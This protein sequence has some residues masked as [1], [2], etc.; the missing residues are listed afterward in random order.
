MPS[1]DRNDI[2]AGGRDPGGEDLLAKLVC[3]YMDRLIAGETI[4]GDRVLREHPDLG[5]SI[6]RE[7]RTFT[8][9]GGDGEDSGEEPRT[10]GTLGDFTLR[11]RLGS[12]GMGVVYAAWQNSL[13]REVALKVLPPGVAADARSS[14]RFLREAQIAARLSHPHIVPVYTTG[15]EGET[16]YYAMEYVEGETLAQAIARMRP[17]GGSSRET[18]EGD[19]TSAPLF[20][21]PRE[22][23]EFFLRFARAFAGVADG[24]QHAHER[25]VIHRDIKPSNLIF[26][27]EGRLRIL[28]FGLA[29]LEGHQS[30][31][32]SGGIAGTPLYMSPEQARACKIPI[33]HRTDIYSLGATMYE[34]L[35]GRPPFKGKDPNDTLSQIIERE[36]LDPTALDP[37]IPRDLETIVLKCL[38]KEAGDRFGT[39]EALAQDLRRFVRGDPIEARPPGR[40]ERA[41]RRLR[42]N[43][44]RIAGAAVLGLVLILGL[45]LALV[46]LA[47]RRE[48]A[49]ARYSDLLH[50]GM[51]ALQAGL[52]TVPGDREG[53][54]FS[55]GTLRPP[56]GYGYYDAGPAIEAFRKGAE[57]LPDRVEAYVHWSRALRIA[58]RPEDARAVLDESLR[59]DPGF[60][61]AFLLKIHDLRSA[62]RQAEAEA[63]S[64]MLEGMPARG[65]QRDWIDA[66]A[67]AVANDWPRAV[68]LYSKLLLATPAPF[69]GFERELR[70][71]RGCV[72]LRLGQRIRALRDLDYIREQS[73]GKAGPSIVL[74]SAYY[75]M[76]ERD[77]GWAILQDVA[78]RSSNDADR[79]MAAGVLTHYGETDRVPEIAAGFRDPCKRFE[80]LLLARPSV[81]LGE[82]ALAAGCRT[83]TILAKYAEALL[84]DKQYRVAL[85]LLRQERL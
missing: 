13:E 36:P 73:N 55:L 59:R 43:A 31:T 21:V 27:G 53:E 48:E 56:G 20:G 1:D 9:I 71:K 50:E 6:L 14:V 64:A 30:L 74:A 7:L 11:R 28:D 15:I 54:A 34:I 72:L 57:I 35:A 2:E 70:F 61:P 58:R 32:R 3:E 12:G 8:E 47:Q 62:G 37:R 25:S 52:V 45:A 68:D 26:D 39:A 66:H 22:D 63:L 18:A 65:W 67:A 29:R 80:A 77:E 41:A 49:Q 84:R 69:G 85:D 81:A 78:A 17:R 33:D 38:R 76:D 83:P 24:L 23:Q 75:E 46:L 4:D 19:P 40:L 79:S 44:W 5:P 10:L 82:E 42:R 51:D 16:P 60:P